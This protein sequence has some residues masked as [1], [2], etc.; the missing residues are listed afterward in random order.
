MKKSTIL[1]FTLLLILI[2]CVPTLACVCDLPVK[3]ISLKKAVSEAKAKA[4]IVFSGKVIEI[5]NATVKF[6]VEG[7][8]KGAPV[9]EIVMRNDAGGIVVSDCAYRFVLGERYLVY[10]SASVNGLH[11]HKC[12]R[13]AM[14]ESAGADVEALEKIKSKKP[15][16]IKAP[17]SL[18]QSLTSHSR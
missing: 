1:L 11:T 4:D 10:A 16:K 8:W 17:L 13:T 9:R 14:L 6:S 15:E 2:S 7:L 12:S 3:R 5:G 18:K